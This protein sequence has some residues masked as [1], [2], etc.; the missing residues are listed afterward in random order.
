VGE[1][2]EQVFEGM[3]V[4]VLAEYVQRGDVVVVVVVALRYVVVLSTHRTS[5]VPRTYT[6]T[7]P[8][9]SFP[10]PPSCDLPPPPPHPLPALFSPRHLHPHKEN[11]SRWLLC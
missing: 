1:P 2:E 11:I 3:A 9:S 10:S 4:A 8:P 7:H 6:Y 5:S